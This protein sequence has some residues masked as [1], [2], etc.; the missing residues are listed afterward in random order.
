MLF[1]CLISSFLANV[2]DEDFFPVLLEDEEDEDFV[3]LLEDGKDEGFV[4]LLEDREDED[5]FNVPVE[6]EDLVCS[7]SFFS[8][9]FLTL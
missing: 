5:F 6:N 1:A 8:L 7:F 3:P 4:S 2:V 9:T